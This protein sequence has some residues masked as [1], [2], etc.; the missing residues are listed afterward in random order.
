M[1]DLVARLK[2]R[3]DMSAKLTN[4]YKALDKTQ[5]AADM[6]N[7]S[8]GRMERAAS[9][10]SHAFSGLGSAGKSTLSGI[11]S[12]AR[13]T[14]GA[15]T[16]LKGA[17][18]SA[19]V[20]YAGVINPLKLS[21]DAEQASIAFTTMLGSA[22]KA[23]KFQ[24]DLSKFAVNTPF[25]IAGLRDT[26]K[27]MLGFGFSAQSI[28]PMLTGVGNATAGLGL[29]QDGIDR[30]TLALGQMRAKAKVSGDEIMQLTEA[31][32]PAWDIL[33]KKM[34][35]STGE[36]MK[37]S[38][39]GLIPADKA[40]NALIDGMNQK[41]PNM[42]DAQ[43]KSLLG[44]YNKLKETFNEKLLK[45][46][47]DGLATTLRPRFEAL[48]KWIDNNGA[49]IDR[50]GKNLQATAAAASDAIVKTF[51]GA[52]SYVKNHFL[53]NPAFTSIPDIPGKIRFIFDDLND[54]Y[55]K[56]YSSTGADAIKNVTEQL[57]SS[58]SNAIQVSAG[59][60]AEAGMSVGR[61]LGEGLWNGLQE[62]LAKYPL[63][64][65]LAGG[66]AG[67]RLAGPLGGAAG[68]VTSAAA[69]FQSQHE[70]NLAG[71]GGNRVDSEMSAL[72]DNLN[73]QQY[74]FLVKTPAERLQNN[75][76]TASGQTPPKHAGGLSHVPYN[77]YVSVLHKDERVLT[78]SENDAY[79]S[80]GGRGGSVTVNVTMNGTTI[81]EDADI[82]RIAGAIARKMN[83]FGAVAAVG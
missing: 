13:G 21:S 75:P 58:F 67:F 66:I 24:K 12:A 72:I 64:S 22:E 77:G 50:W 38:E 23:A 32:I 3:D 37:L 54:T 73:M 61:S 2:L 15:L 17:L 36:V 81:R 41:F 29:G 4:V 5:Q 74:G 9:S 26:S 82:D 62:T 1:M 55:T 53:D 80:G 11:G 10:A 65:M 33:A 8:I 71:K 43:S 69:S 7:S 39:K 47:G 46:W 27:K 78:K 34:H 18:I 51:E 79:S 6:T 14:I 30:I 49:T 31:G 45:K 48:S 57:V 28:I 19:G 63:L 40:I 35:I 42:M 56:W 83:G 76:F 70:Q 25:D 60:I 44:M 52:F 16:S 59:P 68:V 20:A